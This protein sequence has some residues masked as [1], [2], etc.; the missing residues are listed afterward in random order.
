MANSPAPKPKTNYSDFTMTFVSEEQ[1]NESN[2]YQYNYHVENTGDGYIYEIMREKNGSY[3][4]GVFYE[5]SETSNF[6]NQIIA[7][8]SIC[9]ISYQDYQ[10]NYESVT[11]SANA[12]TD[13][14]SDAVLTG[15]LNIILCDEPM[16][17]YQESYYGYFV[18]LQVK[19]LNQEKY[20]YRFI[21]NITYDNV[22]YS[23]IVYEMQLNKDQKG[24]TFWS[25]EKLDLN[26]LTLQDK[27]LVVA[28][29]KY[30]G[31]REPSINIVAML[32]SLG[33]VIGGA[34][35]FCGIYFPI[36]ARKKNDYEK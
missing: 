15:S 25:R 2:Y 19:G 36:K 29:E 28:Q 1:V 9:D 14:S 34:A 3:Y 16:Y 17:V 6:N 20:Y 10:F 23:M 32:I 33:V 30:A 8:H 4:Y 12:Y 13:F 31:Y 11:Y 5:G 22:N 24:Y 18:D 21:L 27:P 26:K 35:I 7:P